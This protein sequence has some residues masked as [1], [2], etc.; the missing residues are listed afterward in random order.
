LHAFALDAHDMVTAAAHFAQLPNLAGWHV[1]AHDALASQ[2]VGQP[3]RVEAIGFGSVPS[4]QPGL[5]WIDD[6]DRSASRLDGIDKR[7]RRTGRFDGNVRS[8][9]A[10]RREPW[11]PGIS[12]IESLLLQAIARDR[13]RARLEERL[14][15]INPDILWCHGLSSSHSPEHASQNSALSPAVGEW[16]ALSFD[17]S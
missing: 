6:A 9:M 7:P 10:A 13:H 2:R 3:S 11:D 4:L 12:P 5:A 14:V 15:Q 17:Q 1:D 16:M 8:G